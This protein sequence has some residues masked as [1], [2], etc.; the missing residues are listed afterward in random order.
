MKKLLEIIQESFPKEKIQKEFTGVLKDSWIGK[1]G[2]FPTSSAK[3]F[4]LKPMAIV[5]TNKSYYFDKRQPFTYQSKLSFL[6][7]PTILVV[8]LFLISTYI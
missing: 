3:Y 8:V 4:Y 7:G 5:E 2:K 1:V 6:I